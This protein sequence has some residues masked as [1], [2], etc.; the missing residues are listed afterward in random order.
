MSLQ[1]GRYR[2]CSHIDYFHLSFYD[3]NT[4]KVNNSSTGT[5]NDPATV[6]FLQFQLFTS[7]IRL[8]Q[9][10]SQVRLEV[11]QVENGYQIRFHDEGVNPRTSDWFSR[12]ANL[13]VRRCLLQ[14][15]YQVIN[16][17][18]R[19]TTVFSKGPGAT[20]CQAA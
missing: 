6:R 16:H 13:Q 2:I 5:F 4:T 14:A 15:E 3:S 17:S 1:E 19:R 9:R 11:K 20:L 7:F 18:S 10:D 8:I 12:K